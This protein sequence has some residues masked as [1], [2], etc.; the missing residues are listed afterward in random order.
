M[1]SRL[2]E[3][4]QLRSLLSHDECDRADRFRFERH[5]Q[6]FVIARAML[7]EVLASY[8]DQEAGECV[9]RVREHGK[10]AVAS[11]ELQFNASHSDDLVLVAVTRAAHVGVDI[12]HHR[13]LE[14]L[15]LAERFF[16]EHE[17]AILRAAGPDDLAQMFFR[18]WTRKEAYVKARGQ[19]LSLPLRDFAVSLDA[20]VS[21][22]LVWS[23][24][25]AAEVERWELRDLS[26][27]SDYTAA[28]VVERPVTEVRRFKWRSG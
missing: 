19:G 6:A 22:A 25:G 3:L 9:V 20:D 23:S 17:V 1:D 26:L 16:S 14:Y 27:G 7:R 11:A 4:S 21:P 5:R 2:A 15:E 10:P 12:E 24:E 28:I 18:C 13:P 8:I